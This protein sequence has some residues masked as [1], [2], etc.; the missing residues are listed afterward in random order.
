VSQLAALSGI[1]GINLLGQ[2]WQE[3]MI[4]HGTFKAY[5]LY[6]DTIW[7]LTPATNLSAGIRFTR[8]E[9][10]FSWYS[11][12]RTAAGLDAQLAV[13]DAAGLL[14][15]LPPEVQAL[16]T[17]NQLLNGAGAQS[18]PLAASR[19][20]NDVSPR[21][22]IDHRY[23][24]G[25]MTYASIT[26][27]YQAG[28]FNALQVNGPVEPERVTSIELGAKGQ[29]QSLAFD[30]AWFHYRFS[31]L[32]TLQFVP[33]STS[34]GVPSYQVETSDQKASGVDLQARWQ[35]TQQ[36]RLF[37]AAEFIDQVYGHHVSPFGTDLS[38][39]P[40][41]TPRWTAMAGVDTRWA[42][43]GGNVDLTLQ[44][45]YR[46]ATRC[47]GDSL[48][49]GT[50]LEVPAFRVGGAQQRFDAS[51]GWE[52]A[53]KRVGVGLVVNN[54]FDRRYVSGVSYQAASIGAPYATISA[55]RTLAVV[56]KVAL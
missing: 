47:N 13:L 29:W 48:A 16:L 49:A 38:G 1:P 9:K 41:G 21:L 33:A 52:S 34:T 30:A 56:L 44:T 22:V 43:A 26:R 5:A 18:A 39:Q 12:L 31:N 4:N 50:C 2:S 35:A 40:V 32:Q 37:G 45:A 42:A 11:P 27:G 54:L 36:L 19:A 7:H 53:D 23:G 8:D 6:G 14:A 55:P 25:L 3:N 51:L 24:P 15:A 46:G 28:G 20:W 10:R 17:T